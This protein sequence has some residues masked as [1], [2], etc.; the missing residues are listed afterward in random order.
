VPSVYVGFVAF[1]VVTLLF[2]VCNELLIEARWVR[3]YYA[4]F[5]IY[6]LLSIGLLLCCRSNQGDDEKWWVSILIFLGIYIV[7]MMGG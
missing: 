3:I 1:G 5:L 6:R 2:L 4:C 7:L